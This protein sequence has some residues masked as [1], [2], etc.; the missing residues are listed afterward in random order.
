MEFVL[1]EN[2]RRSD[3]HDTL[4]LMSNISDGK[5]TYVGIVEDISSSGLR[6]S[7]VPVSFDD[8]VDRCYSVVTGPR[9]DLTIAIQPRWVQITNNGMYKMIGFQIENP[10]SNWTEFV[11][12][13][14]QSVDP[15]SML[16]ADQSLEM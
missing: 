5:S 14:G 16:V 1:E 3:R 15:F 9:N 6:V 12:D 4:G 13:L 2:S 11:N 10:P 8:T 7:K